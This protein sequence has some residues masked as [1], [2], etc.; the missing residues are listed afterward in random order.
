MSLVRPAVMA[1]H[2][3]LTAI[4][5]EGKLMLAFRLTNRQG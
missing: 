2:V 4:D 1:H 5:Y 3:L